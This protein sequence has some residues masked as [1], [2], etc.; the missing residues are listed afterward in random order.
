MS[1]T[2]CLPAK[3]WADLC[4]RCVRRAC[5]AA[6]HCNHRWALDG[7]DPAS[8][9]GVLW[10]FGKQL[11][12]SGTC[13]PAAPVLVACLLCWP[14]GWQTWNSLQACNCSHLLL[15]F[16]LQASTT[17]PR[18]RQTPQSV[19]AWPH[20]PPQ[21]QR[22]ACRL[23]STRRCQCELHSGR[24]LQRQRARFQLHREDVEGRGSEYMK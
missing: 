3:T 21:P 8:Y 23:W 20:A 5:S 18:Q 16:S 6:L 24:V 12:N 10:C 2:W 13:C 4:A 1:P 7:C 9:A 17:A 11:R 22:G 19:A 14:C 15:F